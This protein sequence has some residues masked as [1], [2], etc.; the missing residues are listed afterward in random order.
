MM[1]IG[2]FTRWSTAF[3]A[4]VLFTMYYYFG[5]RLDLEPW[6]HH[7]TY[8]LCMATLLSVF[9]PAGRS[10]SLDRY[11]AVA[12]ARVRGAPR[13][14]ESGNLAGLRLMVIQLSLIYFWAA[15]DKSDAVWISGARMEHYYLYFYHGP[16]YPLWQGFSAVMQILAVY[17]LV[18]EYLLAFTL[19]F[20]ASRRYFIWFGLSL[21]LL[22]YILL[23][24]STYSLTMIL[25]YLAYFDADSVHGFI[26]RIQGHSADSRGI[27]S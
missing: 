6:T 27:D 7:H 18:L 8:L 23:P 25:L 24:V 11:L 19:P 9:T 20:R 10:Y 26:D 3:T 4:I 17:V 15:I 22:F 1:L 2:L 16:I 12:R 13:P 5:Y 14:P 21:H